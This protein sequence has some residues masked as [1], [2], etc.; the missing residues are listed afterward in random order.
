MPAAACYQPRY[1]ER[2]TN[3]AGHRAKRPKME[4]DYKDDR[5]YNWWGLQ[6]GDVCEES[7]CNFDVET[8]SKACE[9]PRCTVEF[10][11]EERCIDES[12]QSI[13]EATVAEKLNEVGKANAKGSAFTS[14]DKNEFNKY[15]ADIEMK[16]VEFRQKLGQWHVGEAREE[17]EASFK[18]AEEHLGLNLNELVVRMEVLFIDECMFSVSD[19]YYLDNHK[20]SY[21]HLEY[22]RDWDC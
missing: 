15:Y 21:G 20:M 16:A 17:L 12:I 13:D 5:Y 3:N 2:Q 4:D 14:V 6:F 1:K 8:E 9:E 7:V 22:G 18:L 11:V 19:S 10:F